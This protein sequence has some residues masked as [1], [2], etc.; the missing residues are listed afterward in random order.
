[1]RKAL[2][3]TA[4][5]VVLVVGLAA[6]GVA[7]QMPQGPGGMMGPGMGMMGPM[8][9][10]GMGMMGPMMGPEM[11][12]MGPMMGF[13]EIMGAMMSIHGETMSLMGQMT[14][15]YGTPIGEMSPEA[16]QKMRKEMVERIGEILTRHGTALKHMARP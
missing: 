8:M 13:P 14:Q 3:V 12:M 15:K 2:V 10:R 16:E 4:A 9:G 7:Q 1:M 6:F 11:G 5:A